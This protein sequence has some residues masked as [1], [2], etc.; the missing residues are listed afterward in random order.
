MREALARVKQELGE[1]AVI[2]GTRAVVSRGLKGVIGGAAIEIT[3]APANTESPAPRASR[4]PVARHAR[5]TAPVRTRPTPARESTLDAYYQELVANEVADELARRI[6]STAGSAAGDHAGGQVRDTFRET[7]ARMLPTVGPIQAER[8]RRRCVAFVGPA[9]A[10]KTTTVAKLAAHFRLR[11]RLDVAIVSLDAHGLA[12]HDSVRRFGELI[13]VPVHTPQSAEAAR[14][15]V[16]ALQP[17]DLVL[18]DTSGIGAANRD[19]LQRLSEL[20]SVFAPDERHLVLPASMNATAQSKSA[21][22]LAPLRPDRLLLTRL[23]EVVGMGVIL[24]TVARLDLAL[25]YT[26]HGQRVPA[27]IEHACARQVAGSILV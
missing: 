22:L 4:G 10:G 12:R 6:L 18:V 13:G 7:I 24:N 27:D 8:G 11:Q 14:L 20:L 9:G 23:D 5:V 25:S 2:L 17:R 3:A 16:V 1:Q 15:T 19:R 21:D 26:T